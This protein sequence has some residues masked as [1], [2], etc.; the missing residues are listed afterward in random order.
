MRQTSVLRAA[1]KN[2][3]AALLGSGLLCITDRR[4]PKEGLPFRVPSN[5]DGENATSAAITQTIYDQIQSK[6]AAVGRLTGR[7]ADA[8]FGRIARRF[9]DEAFGRSEAPRF[10][11]WDHSTETR[12][13]FDSDLR[14]ADLA[15]LAAR[16]PDVAVLLCSGYMAAA[17]ALARRDPKSGEHIADGQRIVDET[18]APRSGL[19]KRSSDRTL[20]TRILYRWTLSRGLLRA[21]L[22]GGN[23]RGRAP[24]IAVVTGE[25]L[26]SRLAALALGSDDTDCVYHIALPE[27]VAGVKKLSAD[28]LVDLVKVMIGRKRLKDIADLP[29]DLAV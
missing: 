23:A 4:K 22:Q 13:I 12:A 14:W 3:H 28:D 25:P 16:E 6:S 24:H 2:F 19:R 7:A 9:I 29:G 11:D 26:P 21:P 20:Q 10:D 15:R 5:A 1:R 18:V 8:K 17:E 27:L